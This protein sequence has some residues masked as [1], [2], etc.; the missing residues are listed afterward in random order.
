MRRELT[1]M[2]VEQAVRGGV[3]VTPAEVEH[4]FAL[5]REEA[6]AAWA[7]VEFGP[8]IAA[9]SASDDELGKYL[10]AHQ[11]EFRQPE[12]RR[13][14][15]VTLTP[16]DF[17]KPVADAAVEQYYREHPKA[18]EEPRRVPAAHVLAGVP[19]TGGSAAE[20][21]ERDTV[22]AVI[23]RSQAGQVFAKHATTTPH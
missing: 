8:L 3:K 23:R 19:E 1:R 14:L 2:K 15:S 10:G 12:R 20:G 17:L 9:A 5:R 21:R 6:R 13:I 4:A 11:D 22:A 7:L 18:F 16:T